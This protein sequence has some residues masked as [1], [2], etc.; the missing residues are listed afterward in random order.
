MSSQRLDER[1]A[2]LGGKVGRRDR[3][4][5]GTTKHGDRTAGSQRANSSARGESW[6]WYFP[7]AKGAVNRQHSWVQVGGASGIPHG[8]MAQEGWQ[9]DMQA[10]RAP[11]TKYTGLHTLRHF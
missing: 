3:R 4:D 6:R 2:T 7:T 11:K 8:P 5:A 1:F 9:A 10:D